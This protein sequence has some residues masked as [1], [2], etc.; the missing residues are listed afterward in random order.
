MT[1]QDIY[2]LNQFIKEYKEIQLSVDVM[3]E[4]IVSMA[5]KRDLLLGRLETLK[6]NERVFLS[7]LA[8][9]YGDSEIT[10]NKLMQY[11]E[12]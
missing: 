5:K 12:E 2:K 8:S 11:V 6:R 9:R 10:P 3:Q 4:S 7:E 1:Q